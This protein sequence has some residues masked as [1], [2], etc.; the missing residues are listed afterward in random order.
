MFIYVSGV[1]CSDRTEDKRLGAGVLPNLGLTFI[2]LWCGLLAECTRTSA[3]TASHGDRELLQTA[4]QL[5]IQSLL[6]AAFPADG[7]RQNLEAETHL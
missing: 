7:D 1:G 5:Q 2:V 4:E 3:K 6:M